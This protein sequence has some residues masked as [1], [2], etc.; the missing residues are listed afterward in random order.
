MSLGG[1]SKSDGYKDR[2]VS[3]AGLTVPTQ[4]LGD[5]VGASLA[6]FIVAA[7]DAG[8]TERAGSWSSGTRAAPQPRQGGQHE[9]VLPDGEAVGP[10]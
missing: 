2:S 7:S 8:V 10:R 1:T 5:S 6:E 9:A 3:R 4:H